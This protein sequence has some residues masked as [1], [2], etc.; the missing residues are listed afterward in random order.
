MLSFISTGCPLS[1]G[2]RLVPE[3]DIAEFPLIARVSDS[4]ELLPG[5][6]TSPGF[7]FVCEPNMVFKMVHL[8]F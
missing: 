3:A 4:S 2:Y 6:V 8:F 5:G 7:G 1:L